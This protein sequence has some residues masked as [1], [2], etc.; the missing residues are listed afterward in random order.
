MRERVR[1]L[2]ASLPSSRALAA[3]QLR[4]PCP[5]PAQAQKPE[6]LAPRCSGGVLTAGLVFQPVLSFWRSIHYSAQ[7]PHSCHS[8]RAP[9]PCHSER[10]PHP[11]IL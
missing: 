11:V 1:K 6:A 9:P 5:C 3:Q 8:E 2:E 7:S 10:A 4:P